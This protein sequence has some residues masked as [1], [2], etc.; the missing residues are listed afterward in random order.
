MEDINT[1]PKLPSDST[2]LGADYS[3]NC[4]I[5]N[6]LALGQTLVRDSYDAL[7]GTW[8][9]PP[10]QTIAGGGEISPLMTIS[11]NKGENISS[12]IYGCRKQ[13]ILSLG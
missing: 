11:D 2:D 7:R 4:T 1:S 12:G 5:R 8:T 3:S 10:P 13:L 6:S 9:V